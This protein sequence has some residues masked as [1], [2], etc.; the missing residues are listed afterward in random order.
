MSLTLSAESAD[1]TNPPTEPQE[2]VVA[3]IK[4]D[5]CACAISV[6][7]STPTARFFR[8]LAKRM[9]RALQ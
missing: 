6:R 5:N 3:R 4:H 1:F 9:L 7:R 2:Q 8:S